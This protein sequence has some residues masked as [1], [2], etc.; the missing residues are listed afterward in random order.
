M[1]TLKKIITCVLILIFVFLVIA[2]YAVFIRTSGTS[3]MLYGRHIDIIFDTYTDPESGIQRLSEN[4]DIT[5]VYISRATYEEMKLFPVCENVTDLTLDYGKFGRTN[6][7]L[8]KFPNVTTLK[9]FFTEINLY[10]TDNDKVEKITIDY[11][12]TKSII[13]LSGFKALKTLEM[14][15]PEFEGINIYETEDGS[16]YVLEDSSC[17]A[18]LDTV[19]TLKI[20]GVKIYDFSGFLEMDSL[21]YLCIDGDNINH[22][23]QNALEELKR[24]GIEIST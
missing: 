2:V 8:D 22:N 13:R 18:N 15:R 9:L 23:N 3:R 20:Q 10:G 14:S 12:K 5:S 17:F 21:K 7:F 24:K 16:M 6:A 1:D 4:D 11:G 19:E